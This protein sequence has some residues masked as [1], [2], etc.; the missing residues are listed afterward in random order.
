MKILSKT[1]SQKT[2]VHVKIYKYFNTK[3]WSSKQK[4]NSVWLPI[5]SFNNYKEKSN[6]TNLQ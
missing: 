4:L 6:K 1:A 3:M 5:V 2:G